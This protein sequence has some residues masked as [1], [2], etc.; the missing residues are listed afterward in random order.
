VFYEAWTGRPD[1]AGVTM[2]K[3]MLGAIC[4]ISGLFCV[5]E[6]VRL[7]PDRRVRPARQIIF[8]NIGLMAMVLWL[9][10]LSDSATSTACLVIGAFI[11]IMLRSK[12]AKANPRRVTVAIPL[13]VSAY[14][15]L[16]FAFDIS[17]I[18][19]QLLGRD[20]T[21]TGRTGMWSELLKAQTSF[22][23]GA[24][25]QSFWLGD[26]LIGIW[27]SL[28][29][30]FLNEAHNGYLETYLNLGLIG[31]ALLCFFMIAS[32]RTVYRQ[33]T[34]SPHL[35]P[36]SLAVWTVVMF[37]NLTEAAFGASLLWCGLLLCVVAVPRLRVEATTIQRP[38]PKRPVGAK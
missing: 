32:Y 29:V 37:Y 2:T 19:I 7:W 35:A 6:I 38:T 11:I 8:M 25:Y 23:F 15:V 9:M 24:G 5:W 10:R 34:S 21:L 26:R 31:L 27:R 1:Y 33:F 18:V 36:L 17:N 20:P 30:S 22:L 16:E 12:W 14:V 28:G 3:N 4:L 13:A